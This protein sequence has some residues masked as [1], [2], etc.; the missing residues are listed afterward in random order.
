MTA[1]ELKYS[2][3]QVQERLKGLKL[4]KHSSRARKIYLMIAISAF[5]LIAF[6][7][8]HP[9]IFSPVKAGPGKKFWWRGIDMSASN[10]HDLGGNRSSCANT[11]QGKNLIAD[12]NGFVCARNLVHP[13]TG[14]CPTN[15]SYSPFNCTSCAQ[16]SCCVAF[17]YC[18]S[19]CLGE[20]QNYIVSE[21]L[22]QSAKP[23]STLH[24]LLYTSPSPRDRTR[25]RMPSSA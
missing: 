24:C 6:F 9:K 22:E 8:L 3:V 23:E 4:Q 5:C 7:Y 21:I 15:S 12:S 1:V 10:L 11:K 16:N 20:K 14:C 17:E 13:K 25:S 18:V 19:C 2:E